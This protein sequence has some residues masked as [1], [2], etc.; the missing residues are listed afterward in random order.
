MSQNAQVLDT[1]L[2]PEDRLTEPDNSHSLESVASLSIISKACEF[3]KN[4][5][6]DDLCAASEKFMDSISYNDEEIKVILES[7]E[8]QAANKIWHSMRQ[9]LF[10]TSNF[11]QASHYIDAKK[12][13][14]PS[15]LNMIMGRSKIDDR[16][17]PAPL[18]WG[19][20]K[21]PVARLMYLKLLRRNHFSMKVQEKGFLLC[22]EN[23]VLGCSVDGLVSCNCRPLHAVKLIEIKCPYAS[24]NMLPKDVAVEKKLSYNQQSGKWEV[25]PNCPYY[26]QIQG[27]LG[28]FG[29]TECDLVIYTT[30]GIHIS[31]ASFDNAYF[32]KMLEKLLL[33]HQKY[34]LPHI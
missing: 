7:T 3:V 9:G 27:Q 18:K 25:T 13:P 33:F 29:L 11:R 20:R 23:P 17:L 32:L 34:V 19:R 1:I 21:E 31:T 22:Q 26:D 8:G 4:E 16:L 6:C 15:F 2:Q 12:E 10:T 24:R 28:L 30:K 5:Q 14:S